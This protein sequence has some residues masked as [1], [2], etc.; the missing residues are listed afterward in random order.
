MRG[1]LSLVPNTIDGLEPAYIVGMQLPRREG[2]GPFVGVTLLS[3]LLF[4]GCA[5]EKYLAANKGVGR[6]CHLSGLGPS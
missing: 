1:H 6:L 2:L 4:A 3:A 5:S